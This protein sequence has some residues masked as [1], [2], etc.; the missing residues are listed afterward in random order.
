MNAGNKQFAVCVGGSALPLFSTRMCCVLQQGQGLST[1]LASSVSSNVLCVAVR[2]QQDNVAVFR[3]AGG[4][5]KTGDRVCSVR[6]R[7]GDRPD[8]LWLRR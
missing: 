7:L 4:N 8:H 1:G 5:S 2:T 3:V 6:A